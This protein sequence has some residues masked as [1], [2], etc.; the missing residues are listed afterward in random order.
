[1]T[2]TLNA[3][4]EP[5][6]PP[7]I[8]LACIPTVDCAIDQLANGFHLSFGSIS[9]L[10]LIRA[11]FVIGFI[12]I[13]AITISRKP[14][15]LRR[16]P[17]PATGALILLGVMLSKQWLVTG[18]I[19][20]ETYVAYGQMAYW[21]LLWITVAVTCV[22]SEEA[23]LML[24]GLASGAL[25]TALSVIAGCAFGGLNYYQEELAFASSGWFN[26]AK[27]ITGIL[28]CGSAVL[29]YLGRGGRKPW[30]YGSLSALCGASVLLTF[31]RA[32]ALALFMV[33]L[34]FV[35][36]VAYRRGVAQWHALKWFLGLVLLVSLLAPAVVGPRVMF[37]RWTD[38]TEG[39]RA[40]SGRA[41][42]W[43]I[44][45][46][47]FKE[48]TLPTQLLGSGYQSMS[49]HLYGQYGEDVK[50][51]HNDAL[52]MLLVGGVL[53]LAWLAAFICT[54]VVRIS[55]IDPWGLEGAAA[56]AVLIDYLCH[57]EATGQLWGTDVMTYY[58]LA[59]TSFTVI[60]ANRCTSPQMQH[61]LTRTSP[62]AA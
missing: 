12:L 3:R 44:S 39:E 11:V 47:T 19:E 48:A 25:L 56:I 6:D 7:V 29:V 18:T 34:W 35:I 41:A 24:Y 17:L 49:E 37:T 43:A 38:L 51:T 22:S 10:Q 62:V 1:M 28:V 52:D 36:W 50:H 8:A 59:L 54:W 53:G 16:I 60:A 31:A 15:R 55:A 61:N 46:D 2:T 40:G 57:A 21:V 9:V 13:I 42:I 33:V 5:F 30:I 20:P 26:T 23:M 32:G 4:S 58:V 27:M 14:N 45:V